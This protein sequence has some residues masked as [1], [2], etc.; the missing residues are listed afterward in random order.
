MTVN[1]QEMR[2]PI[3]K[4]QPPAEITDALLLEWVDQIA[5]TPDNLRKAISGLSEDQLDTPY[6]PG[7]WSVRQVVH[8]LPDSHMNSYVRLKLALTEDT[9]TI[10]P[11]DEG[12]WAATPENAVTPVDVS[13]RLLEGLHERWV[14]LLR[15]MT[16]DDFE[17]TFI[18]PATGRTLTLAV[19]TGL[20]AWHGRHHVG[21]I[22]ALR[23][24]EGW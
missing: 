21:H 18:H 1:E 8:H 17:R 22:T 12:L 7:G 15:A 5:Q 16:P 6:R 14:C 13:I 20:Y 11:Y 3:G 4:F 19:T 23:T 24:R 9:P 2:Y 10:R